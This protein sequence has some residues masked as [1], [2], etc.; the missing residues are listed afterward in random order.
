MPCVV[1]NLDLCT[2]CGLCMLACSMEHVDGFNP[3]LAWVQVRTDLMGIPLA[4]CFTHGCDRAHAA[5][6]R[7]RGEMP[8][9]VAVCAP[10]ALTYRGDGKELT[11]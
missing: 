8:S 9:C 11:A 4:I 6:C 2:G 3:R 10:R 5:Q 1:S 7:C